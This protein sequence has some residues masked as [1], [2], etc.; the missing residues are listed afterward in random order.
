MRLCPYYYLVEPLKQGY[1]IT[2]HLQVNILFHM[3]H[4]HEYR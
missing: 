2:T 1:L 3:A 4:I